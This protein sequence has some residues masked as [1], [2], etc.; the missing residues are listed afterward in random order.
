MSVEWK[1]KC[2]LVM[3]HALRSSISNHTPVLRDSTEVTHLENKVTFSFEMPWFETEG[4]LDMVTQEWFKET[5]GD[6]GTEKLQ[7][8]NII[9][10]NYL[11]LGLRI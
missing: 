9:L 5:R 7:F 1:Q 2:P 3:V 8:K 4:L 6:T 10:E 11:G